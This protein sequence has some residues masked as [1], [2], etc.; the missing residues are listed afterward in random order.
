M[1]VCVCVSVC[2][3][4]CVHAHFKDRKTSKGWKR[5]ISLTE[6]PLVRS[7]DRNPQTCGVKKVECV[8]RKDRE[9]DTI[10]IIHSKHTGSPK[11]DFKKEEEDRQTKTEKFRDGQG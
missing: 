7:F 4:L 2:L 8:R 5:S 3:C 9:K 10:W 1:C 6:K 11:D